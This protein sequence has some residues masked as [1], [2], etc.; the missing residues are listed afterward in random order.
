M[1][2]IDCCSHEKWLSATCEVRH[3]A[4]CA[5]TFTRFRLNSLCCCCRALRS[6]RIVANSFLPRHPSTLLPKPLLASALLLLL[7]QLPTLP[8]PPRHPPPGPPPVP[9][10]PPPPPCSSS[11][12]PPG[13]ASTVAGV[14]AGRGTDD[15]FR[16]GWLDCDKPNACVGPSAHVRLNPSC[17]RAGLWAEVAA[18]VTQKVVGSTCALISLATPISLDPCLSSQ[19]PLPV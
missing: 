18:C 5:S 1:N 13:R 7:L 15:P 4:W 8:P 14:A 11:I 12:T 2:A 3:R 6:T 10:H 19:P 9:P 16:I 17:V